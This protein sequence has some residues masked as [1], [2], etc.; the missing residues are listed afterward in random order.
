MVLFQFLHECGHGFGSQLNKS[1]VSTWFNRV[2]DSGK[3]PKDLDVQSEKIVRG[4]L[5]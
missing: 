3:L 4:T 5:S 1:P 2:G